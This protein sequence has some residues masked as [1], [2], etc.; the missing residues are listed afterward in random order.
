VSDC[1]AG[2]KN[3]NDEKFENLYPE[4]PRNRSWFPKVSGSWHPRLARYTDSATVI[5]V[6][7]KNPDGQTTTK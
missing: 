7:W 5:G 6:L 1:W 3:V 4:I 2:K